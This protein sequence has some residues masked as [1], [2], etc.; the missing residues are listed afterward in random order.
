MIK[1]LFDVTANNEVINSLRFRNFHQNYKSIKYRKKVNLKTIAYQPCK[2]WQ[3]ELDYFTEQNITELTLRRGSLGTMS[4]IKCSRGNKN[5]S[6]LYFIF[7]CP[8]EIAKKHYYTIKIDCFQQILAPYIHHSGF[9][10][11]TFVVYY[12]KFYFSELCETK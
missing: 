10:K 1:K 7:L 9:C 5:A 12:W 11:T 2:N 4:D 6:I 3:V 8:V